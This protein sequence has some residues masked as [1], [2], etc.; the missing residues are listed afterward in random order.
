M[1]WKIIKPILLSALII[2][3]SFDVYIYFCYKDKNSIEALTWVTRANSGIP[4]DSIPDN[5]INGYEKIFPGS[6]TN[7][8]YPDLIWYISTRIHDDTHVQINYAYE[9]SSTSRFQLISVA[10]QLDNKL[11][12]KQCIYAYLLNYDFDNNARGLKK[13][14]KVYYNKS[15]EALTPT[16]CMELAIMTKNPPYFNKFKHPDRL[17]EEVKKAAASGR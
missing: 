8:I 11:T 2:Y 9:I 13:A 14:A 1:A 7:K 4:D 10:N 12:H 6:L 17:N 5:I 16:E 3:L 15:I